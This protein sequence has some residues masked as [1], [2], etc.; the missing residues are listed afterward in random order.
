VFPLEYAD[1]WFCEQAQHADGVIFYLPPDDDIIG[2]DYPRHCAYLDKISVP[3]LL[4]R[5]AAERLPANADDRDP[6]TFDTT[7]RIAAFVAQ[8]KSKP[9]S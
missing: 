8:L 1:E 9:Q 6:A 2:W 3:H 7:N 5:S 4:L